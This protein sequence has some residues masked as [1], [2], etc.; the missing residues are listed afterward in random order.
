[1]QDNSRLFL[2]SRFAGDTRSQ[3]G[4]I[5]DRYCYMGKHF[6]DA[7]TVAERIEL[8]RCPEGLARANGVSSA[9]S[10]A[11]A[12]AVPRA[13]Y[14]IGVEGESVAK[15]GV[16]HAPVNRCLSLQQSHYREL[17]LYGA[18]YLVGSTKC[19]TLESAAIVR[20]SE[21][22]GFSRG[23]WVGLDSARAF[24]IV[25]GLADEMGIRVCDAATWVGN[26][27]ARARALARSK[28]KRAA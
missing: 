8:C 20:A 21:E 6:S 1:M 4:W 15:I 28:Y 16:S 26:L 23:E 2:E 13:V 19:E 3:S 9:L 14:V 22:S 11:Q 7:A 12:R 5:V 18:A 17:F 25:M 27:N 10:E 24:E